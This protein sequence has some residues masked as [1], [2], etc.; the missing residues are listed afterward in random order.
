LFGLALRRK[1]NENTK[2]DNV[3]RTTADPNA[4]ENVFRKKKK[5]SHFGRWST[6]FGAMFGDEDVGNYQKS[7]DAR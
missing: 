7:I 6:S 2:Y 5:R 3:E 1:R 4:E